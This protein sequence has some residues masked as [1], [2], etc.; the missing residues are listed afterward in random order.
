MNPVSLADKDWTDP[1]V[2]RKL[3][4]L[5]TQAPSKADKSFGVFNHWQESCG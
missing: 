2:L 3:L 4:R 1:Y 5:Q